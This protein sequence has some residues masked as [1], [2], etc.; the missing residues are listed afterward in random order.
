MPKSHTIHTVPLGKYQ[1]ERRADCILCTSNMMCGTEAVLTN[2]TGQ[3]II[4]DKC[5]FTVEVFV[6]MS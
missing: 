6:L 4:R 3:Q 5:G 1:V 2:V